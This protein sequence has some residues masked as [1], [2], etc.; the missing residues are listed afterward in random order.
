MLSTTMS[1]TKEYDAILLGSGQGSTPLA[2]ALANAGYKTLLI[3]KSHIGGTCVNEGCTPTKTMV[4]SGRVAY[5]ARRAADYGLHAKIDGIDMK[6]IRQR[7]RDIVESFRGGGERRLKG[8]ENL[9]VF[10]GEGVFTGDKELKVARAGGG[11]ELV[12]AG[13]WVFISVGERPAVPKLDG[14]ER[15]MNEMPE[16]VLNSTTI[17]EVDEVPESLI[18]LGGGYVGLEFAHL[19]A[20]LG[21][22]VHIVQR[23]K[24]VLPREDPEVVEVLQDLLRE[25]GLKIHLSTEPVSISPGEGS[26]ALALKIKSNTD[27]STQVVS[28]SH[29][30]L[31]AGRVPNTDNLNLAATGVQTNKRGYIIVNASLETSAPGIYAMGDCKGPPAFTH[32]SYDDFRIIRDNLGL[33]PNPSS[34][35]LDKPITPHTIEKRKPIVPYCCFTDPQLAHVGLHLSEIPLSERENIKVASWLMSWVARGLET[36]EPRGIMKVVVNGETGQI[37]GF[38]CLAPEGGEMMNVVQVA[39][40]G[41][42]KWWDLRE[43]IFAHPTWAEALN[44][45]WGNLKDAPKQ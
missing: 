34:S 43:C 10:D 28:G 30:L 5:L 42:L 23:A 12:K 21:A 31:A 11:E 29:I 1:T 20:R 4:A 45:I 15:I 37:I 6:K 24:Q 7:K 22:Q 40:M 44:N 39:M 14:L 16:R 35:S 27:G 17:M 13:K 41:G 3:E 19:F 8:V 36:D 25:E 2:S 33:L 32:I 9:E 26:N 38:S 18:V